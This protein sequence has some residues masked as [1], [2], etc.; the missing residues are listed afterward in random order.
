MAKEIEHQQ[1]VL[2]PAI[3]AELPTDKHPSVPMHAINQAQYIPPSELIHRLDTMLNTLHR[4]E[5][6]PQYRWG[7]S[8]QM[9][10]IDALRGALM[11]VTQAHNEA[12]VTIRVAAL[13]SLSAR[14][15]KF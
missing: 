13:I 2:T 1:T 15:L 14:I 9:Q 6:I 11:S 4:E 10:A 7:R 12:D 8:V 5:V 3:T